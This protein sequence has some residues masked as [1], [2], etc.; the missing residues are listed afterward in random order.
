MGRYA[1]H[2]NNSNQPRINAATHRPADELWSLIAWLIWV[3]RPLLLS[4]NL[5]VML[6]LVR[7]NGRYWENSDSDPTVRSWPRLCENTA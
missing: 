3:N 5:L 6:C 7:A 1:P 4:I 2:S